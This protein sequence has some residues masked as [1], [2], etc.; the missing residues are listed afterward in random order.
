VNNVSI[1]AKLQLLNCKSAWFPTKS[2][3]SEN[4]SE[5]VPMKTLALFGESS[6]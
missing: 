3:I 4:I 5:K 2:L 1:Y 6:K